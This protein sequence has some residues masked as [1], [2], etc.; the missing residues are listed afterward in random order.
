MYGRYG[1]DTL[2]LV[3]LIA[4]LVI[5]F[6]AQLTRFWPL[7]L[8]AYAFYIYA[9]FRMLSRNTAQR[10]TYKYFKC[11][12]C[13]QQLRAPRGRGKILVTCQRCHKQFNQKT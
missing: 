6:I 7:T 10:Q 4:G 9:I 1:T 11:P 2:N 13:R 12:N 3:L 5:A 8:I